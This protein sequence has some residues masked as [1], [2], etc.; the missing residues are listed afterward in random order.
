MWTMRRVWLWMFAAVAACA[1][2]PPCEPPP[3]KAWALPEVACDAVRPTDR[4]AVDGVMVGALCMPRCND[5]GGD[6]CFAGSMWRTFTTVDDDTCAV[7][8]V[9]YCET[10][11]TP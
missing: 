3:A 1:D 10:P 4:A 2:P 9:C 7:G 11:A 5:D 8:H 6:V